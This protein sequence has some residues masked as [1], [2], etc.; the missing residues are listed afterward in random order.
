MG[1]EH[2]RLDGNR[3]IRYQFDIVG[4]DKTDEE[5]RI[6]LGSYERDNLIWREMAN[7]KP[8]DGER[9]FHLDGYFKNGHAT[10]GMFSP[11]PSYDEVRRMVIDI[12]EGKLEAVTSSTISPVKSQITVKP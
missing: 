1:W 3:A 11:E 12:L 10:Y 7:P 2:F 6:S 5:F 4:K 9:L 8:K